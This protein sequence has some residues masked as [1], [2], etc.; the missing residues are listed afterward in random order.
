M[1]TQS[2]AL[3]GC[4]MTMQ[5]VAKVSISNGTKYTMRRKDSFMVEVRGAA[6]LL[7]SQQCLQAAPE[8]ISNTCIEKSQKQQQRLLLDTR[9]LM[10]LGCGSNALARSSSAQMPTA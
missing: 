3:A 5:P 1:L 2:R 8:C 7:L 9:D 6:S 10:A 4:R